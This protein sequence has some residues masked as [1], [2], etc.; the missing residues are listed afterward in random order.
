MSTVSAG[1]RKVLLFNWKW[2]EHAQHLPVGSKH[3][4]ANMLKEQGQQGHPCL[5][6]ETW[7]L[8][9]QHRIFTS[10]S[11]WVTVFAYP[12]LPFT[13]P[14]HPAP[15]AERAGVVLH[16]C[17]YFE[18]TFRVS[19]R[20]ISLFSSIS[21]CSLRAVENDRIKWYTCSTGKQRILQ[22]VSELFEMVQTHHS[23]GSLDS[24]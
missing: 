10:H 14:L 11:R 5:L 4:A 9:Y 3:L 7:G 16:L 13:P 6:W 2:W 17:S 12:G 1:E 20:F 8:Q 24:R 21:S 23:P 18:L 19:L 22:T 15:R